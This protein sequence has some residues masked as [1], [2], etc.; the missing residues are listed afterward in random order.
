MLALQLQEEGIC[1]VS[2]KILAA[3]GMPISDTIIEY[4]TLQLTCSFNA[5]KPLN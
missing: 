3:L 1:H 2:S 5:T 4:K